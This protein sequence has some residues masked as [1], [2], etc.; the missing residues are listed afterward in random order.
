MPGRVGERRSASASM[1]ITAVGPLQLS[2]LDTPFLGWLL[3]ACKAKLYVWGIR[4]TL[5]KVGAERKYDV[6]V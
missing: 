1:S 2:R 4:L 6:G 3:L 5:R